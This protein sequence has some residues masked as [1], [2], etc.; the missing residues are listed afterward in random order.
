M[1]LVLDVKR[2]YKVAVLFATTAKKVFYAAQS[3][4]FRDIDCIHGSL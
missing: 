4:H 3:K 2:Y 1:T